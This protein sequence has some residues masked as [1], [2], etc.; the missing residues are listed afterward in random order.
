MS[1]LVATLERTAR[2]PMSL[3]WPLV[4]LLAAA[5]LGSAAGLLDYKIALASL[6]LL[7]AL[8]VLAIGFMR[9]DLGVL[10]M[11]GIGFSIEYLRKYGDIPF[12]LALDGL[13]VVFAISML[14]QLAQR[15]DFAFLKHPISYMVLLWMYFCMFQFFNPWTVSRLAW[16]YTVRS[17]AGLLFLYFIALYAFDSLPK[18]K[19]AIKTILVLGFIA[20]VYGINQEFNG[21]T[22]V[23]RD[24]LFSDPKRL[25]L[26]FQWSRMRVFSIFAEPTTCGIVMGYL[27]CMCGVLFFGPYK[28]WQKLAL[29]VGAVCMLLT[30]GYAGS[31]TPVAMVPVGFA[32]FVLLYPKKHILLL[33][34]VLFTFGTLFM[35]KPSGNPVIHRIQSAFKPG[36]DASVQVRLTNQAMVQPFIQTHPIGS[37]LGTTGDWGRRFAPGFWLSSFAHD[38]GLV[39]IAVEGGY[40]GL[41]LYLTFLAVILVS[42]I[43]QFFRVRDPVIKNLTLA[44]VVVMFCLTVASYPQEAIP[45]LPTSLIF[46]ILLACLV[47]LGMLDA[48]QQRG[49]A[50][51][52]DSATF[53]TAFAKT[54]G[55]PTNATTR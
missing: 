3:V 5:G 53:G 37:G 47:R 33:S 11:L 34:A 9:L 16:L 26:I 13:L 19:L 31:R 49:A 29:V 25:Q 27:A 48:E 2:K 17:L 24:W 55:T 39:R 6:V 32:F 45:M 7:T 8:P 43:R 46:Y 20:A 28:K 30:L 22:N 50:G 51:A 52:S 38:S 42:G 21:Y 54:S 12:G 35:L 10:M 36:Q 4:I 1:V 41:I 15:K 23:E 18:I 44:I 14:A 40:I